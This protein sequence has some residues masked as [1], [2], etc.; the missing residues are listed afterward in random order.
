MTAFPKPR[1]AFYF[2]DASANETAKTT[3]AVHGSVADT[4]SPKVYSRLFGL[5]HSSLQFLRVWTSQPED[6][7]RTEEKIGR[8]AEEVKQISPS[9]QQVALEERYGD[10][11]IEQIRRQLS[12]EDFAIFMETVGAIEIPLG[13]TTGG[14]RIVTHDGYVAD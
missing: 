1:G 13:W 2:D 5:A 3:L 14:K 12:A 6:S 10:L 11:P 4:V 9:I 7:F 8:I